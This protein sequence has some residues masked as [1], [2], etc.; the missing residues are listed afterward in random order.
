MIDALI[1]IG[2]SLR[3]KYPSP[4][5]ENPYPD[6]SKKKIPMVLVVD[7]ISYH[8]D[9]LQLRDEVLLDFDEGAV[10]TKYFFRSP[11]SS[12]GPAASL[13]FKLP[14]KDSALKQRLGILRILGYKLSVNSLAE[15]ILNKLKI[16]QE[17][18]TILKNTPVLVVIKIDGKWP[19]ENQKLTQMFEQ[20]FF[21]NLGSYKKKPIWKT[22]GKCHSCG[23]DKEIYGG[24]GNLLKFYTV[25]KYGYAPELNPKIAWKQYAL[26]KDCILDLERG[27]RAID[28]FLTW[29]FYGKTFWLLPVSTSNLNTVLQRFET[30]HKELSGKTH[31]EG[32]GLLED[33]LLYEASM[34]KETLFY[35][36]VF[37]KKDNQALRIMLHIEEVTPSLIKQYLQLKQDMEDKFNDWLRNVFQKDFHF[38]FNFFSSNGLKAIS[39]KPGFTDK[40]FYTLVDKVFK[41]SYIDERHLISKIMARIH[42]DIVQSG[43]QFTLPWG[44]VLESL[45]SLE[46]LL[47]WGVLK[48]RKGGVMMD[49]LP[50]GEFFEQHR[51]FFDHPAKRGLVLLGVLV[52]KFLKFQHNERGS[53]PFM[54][55]LKNLK[56][57]QKDIQH[58]FVSLQ[59]KMNEYGIGHW[60]PELREGISLYL[61]DAGN[62]W[63]LTPDEIGFYIAIGMALSFH[64]VLNCK[65]NQGG[66]Q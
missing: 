11:P 22:Y 6:K 30:L 51:D 13:S 23:K 52:D 26:C 18:G 55:V 12:Q 27:K 24:V 38:K 58:I 10:Y 61:I 60:W 40:D 39:Q 29:K 1:E 42:S 65:E 37:T 43:E 4:L 19:S 36:F 46:F 2:K 66:N 17:E 53:T 41:R 45:L 5:V 32:Y 8:D 16:F 50:Y 47:L 25:D 33:R 62:N 44:T 9:S 28:N 57:N 20:Y 59:N 31:Q 14:G 49:N 64:P 56:L 48:R 21:E 35:H 54:K 63:G 15:K 34:Q 7:L 3:N